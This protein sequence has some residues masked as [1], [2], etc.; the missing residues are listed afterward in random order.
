M[1]RIA[2]AAL[3]VAAGLAS[4]GCSYTVRVSLQ[5]EAVGHF[6]Q[7]PDE[8]EWKDRL[9]VGALRD[10]LVRVQDRVGR[11]PAALHAVE[12]KNNLAYDFLG[13]LTFGFYRPIEVRYFLTQPF[14]PTQNPQ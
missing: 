3:L 7:V 1:K 4:A 9:W 6:K 11:Q 10:D 5:D 2:L 8:P 12:I 14:Q 13:V